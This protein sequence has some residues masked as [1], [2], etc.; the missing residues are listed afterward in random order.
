MR[1]VEKNSKPMASSVAPPPRAARRSDRCGGRCWRRTRR[2]RPGWTR[3]RST[4]AGYWTTRGRSTRAGCWTSASP[5]PGPPADARAVLGVPFRHVERAA[6]KASKAKRPPEQR[7]QAVCR[8]GADGQ[9]LSGEVTSRRA[10]LRGGAPRLLPR[11]VVSG[12]CRRRSPRPAGCL[13][14]DRETGV[15]PFFCMPHLDLYRRERVAGAVHFRR[16]GE[17]ALFQSASP[18]R[19]RLPS[20]WGLLHVNCANPAGPM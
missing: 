4:R 12:G 20:K 16:P 10:L 18:A 9:E 17:L 19:I 3:G 11:E 14:R 15:M 1:M 13:A 7:A 2:R 8:G 5:W 6:P